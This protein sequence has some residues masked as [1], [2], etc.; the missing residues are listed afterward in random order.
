MLLR[1][2]YQPWLFFSVNQN[3][4]L[5][6]E[7]NNNNKNGRI[8][9]KKKKKLDIDFCHHRPQIW[10]FM[11]TAMLFGDKLYKIK[12]I[13]LKLWHISSFLKHFFNLLYRQCKI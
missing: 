3:F 10:G 5:Y 7:A 11:E 12:I 1:N 6:Y 4:F 8:G 9:Q 2:C 13:N